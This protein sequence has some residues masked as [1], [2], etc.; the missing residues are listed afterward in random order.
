ML[1]LVIF[2]HFIH[3]HLSCIANF[4][5]MGHVCYTNL[6][7]WSLPGIM[8]THDIVVS[9]NAIAYLLTQE[10]YTE[11]HEVPIVAVISLNTVDEK[12]WNGWS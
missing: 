6:W 3:I 11:E 12:K 10:K 9:V 8:S 1:S 7:G 4:L 2:Y 5:G